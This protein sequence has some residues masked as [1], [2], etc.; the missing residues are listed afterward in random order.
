[1]AKKVN[2]DRIRRL[3]GAS[4]LGTFIVSGTIINI[5]DENT[6]HT[7]EE[8]LIS[9]ALSAPVYID[10]VPATLGIKHQMQEI[11]SYYE[12]LGEEVEVRF[13]PNHV[14]YHY[15]YV[16]LL[17]WPTL[18]GG[19]KYNVTGDYDIVEIDGVKYAVFA[20][21]VSGEYPAIHT[22]FADSDKQDVLELKR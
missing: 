10:D 21:P 16:R 13:E 18:N 19:T 4:L 3:I 11:K 22:Y 7:K 9:K 14:D 17:E 20:V 1:M 6:D 12:R 8:C 15:H 5:I 2:R